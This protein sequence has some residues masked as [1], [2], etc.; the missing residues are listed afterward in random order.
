MGRMTERAGTLALNRTGRKGRGKNVRPCIFSC[1]CPI[2]RS[3]ET[4]KPL[5]PL[6]TRKLGPIP[7]SVNVTAG[8]PKKR[9]RVKPVHEYGVAALHRGS[10]SLWCRLRS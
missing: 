9:Q 4:D 10:T 7:P 6:D 3:Y 2:S 1:A 5:V 8:P